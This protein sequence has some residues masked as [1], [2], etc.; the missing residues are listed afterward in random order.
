MQKKIKVNF[1]LIFQKKKTGF[2]VLSF[3]ISRVI[4]FQQ[5]GEV[6]EKKR[7]STVITFFF[8]FYLSIDYSP[9]LYLQLNY[10]AI[11]ES[12]K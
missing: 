6:R 3:K 5:E 12:K 9:I 4:L 1:F 11:I 10:I 2:F 7:A 8:L